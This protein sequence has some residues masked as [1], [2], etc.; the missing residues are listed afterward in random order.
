[1]LLRLHL[2]SLDL[3]RAGL[4]SGLLIAFAE[5][6][7]ETHDNSSF[8][9]T[10][11]TPLWSAEISHSAYRLEMNAM[12]ATLF[13]LCLLCTTAALGQSA[14]GGATLNS[15]PQVFQVPSHPAHASPQPM[16]REQNLLGHSGFN[17]AQGERPLWEVAPKSYAMPLGD[18]ARILRKGHA[19]AKK[20]D[21]VWEN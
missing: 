13:V 12:K 15:Q 2:E 6:D 17:Y 18:A 20:A 9:L 4:V 3:S 10:L 8:A 1:V 7:G 16:G 21:I 5:T 19:T 14:V 11:E